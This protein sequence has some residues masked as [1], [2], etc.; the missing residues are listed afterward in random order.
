M[1]W[2]R[3]GTQL[4]HSVKQGGLCSGIFYVDFCFGGLLN[5]VGQGVFVAVRGGNV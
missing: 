3:P 2:W 1:S 5:S 4:H